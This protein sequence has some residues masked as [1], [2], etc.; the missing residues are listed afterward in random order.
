MSVGDLLYFPDA[1]NSQKKNDNKIHLYIYTEIDSPLR[2]LV[3]RTVSNN[4]C[5]NN[6]WGI[7]HCAFIVNLSI[8]HVQNKYVTSSSLSSYV[9]TY[10]HNCPF[11][12]LRH[13]QYN[14]QYP[15]TWKRYKVLFQSKFTPIISEEKITKKTYP[16]HF[17]FAVCLSKV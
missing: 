4:L 13:S 16:E 1:K 8:I 7:L 9:I 14:I 5:Q 3:E 17:R 15:L 12:H 2:R 6:L 11:P 10:F